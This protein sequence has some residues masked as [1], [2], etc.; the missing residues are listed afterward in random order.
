MRRFLE[1]CE[2]AQG[3]ATKTII[4]YEHYLKRLQK[5][6]QTDLKLQ[7]P[8]L[9]EINQEV[10]RK[11]RLYLN[12]LPGSLSRSTQ[13]Y[14]LVALRSFLSW[15]SKNGISTLTP[16]KV[17]LPR[18]SEP[19]VVFLNSDKMT[20]LLAAPDLK[21]IIG[22]R[23]LAIIELLFSTGLRVS[24]LVSLD[25]KDVA[26]KTE[27][28]ILGKGGKRRVVFLSDRARM[29]LDN[30]LKKRQDQLEPLFIRTT[31]GSEKSAGRLTTRSVQRV[32]LKY[33]TQINL[34]EKITPHTIRHTFATDLLQ[35]GADLRSVQTLLGHS[36][37]ATTQRYT[38]VTDK[39]LQEVHQAFH[40]R[41]I[42][43]LRKGG[44]SSNG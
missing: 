29:A 39:H 6:L 5:F 23:D 32:I 41:T 20:M 17:E 34:T 1:D 2:L 37:V 40:A 33:A 24:E 22:L 4:N 9:S 27:V 44:A 42:K 21:T 13:N 31:K 12:H 18:L 8:K 16:E 25:Q 38:H 36:S 30:Y 35:S 43:K 19:E 15:A 11:W 28:T 10:I 26:G 7:D 14:H 3:L